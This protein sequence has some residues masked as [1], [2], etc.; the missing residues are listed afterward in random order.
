MRRS[1]HVSD[2]ERGDGRMFDSKNEMAAWAVAIIG[3]AIMGLIVWGGT[4]NVGPFHQVNKVQAATASKFAPVHVKIVTDPKTIGAYEPAS[5]TVHPGQKVIFTNVST[6]THTVTSRQ[7]GLFDSH[8]I[9]TT[10][11]SKSQ[12]TWT[13]VAPKKA[14]KYA[15][16]CVYHPLMFGKVIVTG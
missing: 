5:V 15:Y 14:G 9:P 2:L 13:L 3:I 10:G 6:Y 12:S 16:Y 4:N 8:D 7:D 11:S 1:A